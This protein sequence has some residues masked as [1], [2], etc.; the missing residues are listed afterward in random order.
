MT[1]GSISSEGETGQTPVSPILRL[2][3]ISK[4]FGETR[5]L[6]DLS[7]SLTP[8]EVV[9]VLG[10]SGSG[11]STLLRCVAGLEAIN[12]GSIELLGQAIERPRQLH[13]QVGFVFQHFNLFP[14][15]T[16]L[17]NVTLALRW[18]KKLDRAT[19]ETRGRT[20]L[21]DVG[22]A[23]KADQRP[24]RLSGGQQQRVAIARS[25]VMQPKLMLFDEVTS[26][27]D[28]ELVAEVLAAIRRLADQGMT[29]LVVTH[30]L[31]FAE[32]VADRIVFMESGTI[33]EEGPPEAVLHRPKAHGLQLFLGALAAADQAGSDAA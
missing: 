13:G 16:A 18:V 33:I 31:P 2:T 7:L 24:G 6:R 23:D 9:V 14:H 30:E 3:D 4:Q 19:S 1:S 26:A 27:L 25:I 32:R 21:A 28:R 12:G 10:R 11:K 8:G 15:L 29:M 22:L 17:G 5:I 20:A